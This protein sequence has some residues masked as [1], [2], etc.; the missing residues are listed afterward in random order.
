M[1]QTKKFTGSGSFINF[2]MANNSSIPVVGLGATIL[3]YSDRSVAEVVEVSED[4]KTCVIEHLEAY[5]DGENNWI[6]K[7]RGQYQ[8]ITYRNGGWKIKSN[9]VT[10]TKEF[11]QAHKGAFSLAN[12]LT[13]EQ[14]LA[15]YD[16]NVWPKNVVEGI[17]RAKT[18]YSP[19]NI[20][21]GQ[22][23]YYYDLSF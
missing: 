17:T 10:F 13:D 2:M 6:F 14:R 3:H 8:T 7:A 20:L 9:G 23:D 22:K 5:A 12:C 18:F 21:F 19:I 16:G 11:E 1:K 4:G 15:V